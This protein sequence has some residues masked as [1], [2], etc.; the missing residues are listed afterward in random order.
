MYG[1]PRKF[2]EVMAHLNAHNGV[3]QPEGYRISRPTRVKMLRRAMLEVGDQT[4]EVRIRNMS[5]AGALIDGIEFPPSA[6]GM[7]VRIELIEGQMF[8]AS[9][10]WSRG[11]LAGVG[12]DQPFNLDRLAPPQQSRILKRT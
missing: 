10:R 11:A 5:S 4:G 2:D 12:F 7:P 9:V 8:A 1:K 6:I 3:A